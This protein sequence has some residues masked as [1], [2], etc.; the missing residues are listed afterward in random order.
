MTGNHQPQ[1]CISS[2]E[3]SWWSVHEFVEPLLKRSGPLPWPGTVTWCELSDHDPAKLAAVLVAGMLW[4]L[5][6]DARQ[7]ASRQASH[8]ISAAADWSVIATEMVQL[9]SFY[10][11]KPWLRRAAA[12]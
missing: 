4:A 2:R 12:S 11:T 3:V 10:A 7:E 9:N 8:D 1:Q 6:E 5:N